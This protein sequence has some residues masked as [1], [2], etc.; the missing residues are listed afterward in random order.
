MNSM[1]VALGLLRTRR[2]PATVAAVR[3]IVQRD[4]RRDFTLRTL[5]QLAAVVPECVAVSMPIRKANS[6]ALQSKTKLADS[7]IIRLDDPE[8]DSGRNLIGEERSELGTGSK[9]MRRA[10]LHRRLLEIVREHH[11]SFVRNRKMGQD[12]GDDR[13]RVGG[14]GG[15]E[16]LEDGG[17]GGR[18]KD[19]GDGDGGVDDDGSAN[20]YSRTAVWHPEFDPNRDVPSLPAPPLFSSS[21]ATTTSRAIASS[22][23]TPSGLSR[24]PGSS[25]ASSRIVST[26]NTP[27][28][29]TGSSQSVDEL[30]SRCEK[31]NSAI[32]KAKLEVDHGRPSTTTN[33]GNDDDDDDDDDAGIP[34]S[35][36]ARVRSREKTKEHRAERAEEERASNRNIITKLPIT[37]DSINTVLR[38]EKRSA[39]GWAQLLNKVAKFHPRKWPK[40]EVEEQMN[41]IAKIATEWCTKVELKSSRGGFAFKVVSERAFAQAR[42]KVCSTQTI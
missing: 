21:S 16:D 24:T 9:L 34:K 37:M 12:D 22:S 25:N 6:T 19:G 2:T 20:Q 29:A 27:V 26:P 15:V 1:E 42:A 31:K 4:I 18:E 8:G 5:A 17:S 38:T 36:L 14:K 11:E 33:S 7:L 10:F 28:S 35:L 39:M 23:S 40:D 32:V 3:E 41:A 30:L 13:Q